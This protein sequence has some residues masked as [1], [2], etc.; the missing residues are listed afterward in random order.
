LRA[1]VIGQ[2][3]VVVVVVMEAV[4]IVLATDH[5]V[6]AVPHHPVVVKT[7]PRERMIDATIVPIADVIALVVVL[8]KTVS[9]SVNVVIEIVTPRILGIVKK[10]A[11]MEPMARSAKVSLKGFSILEIDTN[12]Q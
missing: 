8:Q 6:A 5:L 9:G 1:V 12:V 11:R 4:T 3:K 7:I 10:A 2:E